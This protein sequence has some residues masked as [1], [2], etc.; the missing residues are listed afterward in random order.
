[1]PGPPRT[2]AA[3]PHS[4]AGVGR[5]AIKPDYILPETFS[6]DDIGG[7]PGVSYGVKLLD[8]EDKANGVIK[9]STKEFSA[10]KV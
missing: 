8:N 6:L 2:S 7:G 10:S 5:R 1:M 9:G 3:A 4:F